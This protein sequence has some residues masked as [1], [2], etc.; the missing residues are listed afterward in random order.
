TGARVFVTTH[1]ASLGYLCARGTLMQWGT[2]P[3]D[4]QVSEG[5]CAAC[6]L[7]HR[8]L[9]RPIAAAAGRVAGPL[10]SIGAALP[11]RAGA[12]LAM[13]PFIRDQQ[14]RQERV[15][16]ASRRFVVLTNWASKAVAANGLP[17]G[18]ISVNALGLSHPAHAPK[19]GPGE[20]PTIPPVTFGYLGRLD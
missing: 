16:A 11:G 14:R 17:A 15:F 9:P 10:A 8:G 2:H 1:A 13:R 19:P 18:K 5:K 4:G 6:M 3:C 7:E 20:R 12:A